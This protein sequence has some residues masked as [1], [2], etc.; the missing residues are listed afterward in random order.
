[1]PWQQNTVAV[2][3]YFGEKIALYFTFLGHYTTWLIY[4][5]IAGFISWIDVAGDN[6]NAR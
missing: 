2:K 1:M 3:D 4:A 6:N 5:S